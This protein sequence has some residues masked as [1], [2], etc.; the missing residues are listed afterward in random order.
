MPMGRNPARPTAKLG[1]GSIRP[2]PG[3]NPYQMQPGNA[4]LGGSADFDERTGSYRSGRMPQKPG[5]MIEGPGGWRDTPIRQPGGGGFGGAMQPW[6]PQRPGGIQG[7]GGWRDIP[8][9]NPGGDR[10][11]GG[12]M[13]QKPLPPRPRG[14]FGGG[15]EGMA[16]RQA[17]QQQR[18]DS[19][20]PGQMPQ[21]LAQM[22]QMQQ[23]QRRMQQMAMMRMLNQQ[24]QMGG[25]NF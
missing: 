3:K 6:T 14:F 11:F 5:G 25:G 18:A 9:R 7:P 16:Q 8:M 17:Y 24:Q 19:M 15:P 23:A 12:A 2:Q 13:P 20:M 4:Y 22:M 21:H 10:G 1:G